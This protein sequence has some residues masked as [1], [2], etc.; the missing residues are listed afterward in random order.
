MCAPAPATTPRTS[1]HLVLYSFPIPAPAGR[2][3]PGLR[4]GRRVTT[5]LRGTPGGGGGGRRVWWP[6]R[7]GRGEAAACDGG[8]A[9]GLAPGHHQGRA[10]LPHQQ[11]GQRQHPVRA[12]EARGELRPVAVPAA[13]G[14]QAARL[15]RATFGVAFTLATIP[16][17]S[18]VYESNTTLLSDNS[19]SH[20]LRC[21]MARELRRTR[22]ATIYPHQ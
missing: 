8:G 16:A 19:L 15:G 20:D 14:L 4:A 9:R 17:A 22:V 10:E 18:S 12:P 11:Q 13:L 3:E 21:L 6:G 1:T 2:P 5:P 7:H